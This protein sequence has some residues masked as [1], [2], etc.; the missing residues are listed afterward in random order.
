MVLRLIHFFWNLEIAKDV[1]QK[2]LK[3]FRWFQC[4]WFFFAWDRW[5]SLDIVSHFYEN[6]P[7]IIHVTI[8]YSVHFAYR[9]IHEKGSGD[10]VY[11]SQLF[12]TLYT[13]SIYHSATDSWDDISLNPF[14]EFPCRIIQGVLRRGWANLQVL[15]QNLR[16]LDKYSCIGQNPWVWDNIF[17][18][19][20][21]SLGFG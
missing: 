3:E 13:L 4:R 19:F 1:V 10:V 8:L 14:R 17:G 21:K 12:V 11:S 6:C 7:E 5:A 20:D 18:S 15:G 9:R 2:V 16:V